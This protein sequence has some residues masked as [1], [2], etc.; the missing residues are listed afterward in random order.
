MVKHRAYAE[1]IDAIKPDLPL[2]MHGSGH[3]HMNDIDPGSVPLLSDVTAS[4]V[5]NLV[6]AAVDAH[7]MLTDGSGVAPPTS[8]T[9]NEA[10]SNNNDNE[11]EEED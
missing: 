3:V 2:L 8:I 10:T 7:T 11:E 1:L 4:Y 6:S 5:S 9:N